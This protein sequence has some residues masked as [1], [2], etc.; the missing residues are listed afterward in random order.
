M[1]GF[2][3]EIDDAMHRNGRNIKIA[4]QGSF[5]PSAGC[6]PKDIN[7]NSGCDANA[8]AVNNV[9]MN[10]ADRIVANTWSI[11]MAIALSFLA[12]TTVRGR[13]HLAP[14]RC[15]TSNE[16]SHRPDRRMSPQ[17]P[18]VIRYS[19][20]YRWSRH[21]DEFVLHNRHR[22]LKWLRHLGAQRVEVG[23][24]GGDQQFTVHEPVWPRW[25]G[26]AVERHCEGVA[27]DVI[28]FMA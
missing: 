7:G 6:V 26:R 17:S 13:R 10:P 8:I 15:S 12:T 11:A 4:D 21:A 3:A 9:P 27:L 14:R 1:F 23:A 25:K 19:R 20:R 18:C 28:E 22:G 24:A 2:D 16:H 5:S